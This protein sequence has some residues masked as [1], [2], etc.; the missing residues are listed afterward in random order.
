MSGGFRCHAPDSASGLRLQQKAMHS[1][2]L[3]NALRYGTTL[4]IWGA[5]RSALKRQIGALAPERA[6]ASR[7]AS[8]VA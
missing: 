1:S 6:L 4:L 3:F 8:A 5:T 2:A 7:F